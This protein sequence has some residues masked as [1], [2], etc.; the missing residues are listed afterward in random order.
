MPLAAL[1]PFARARAATHPR[2]FGEQVECILKFEV[3]DT[4]FELCIAGL[5]DFPLHACAPNAG[6]ELCIND[7][8]SKLTKKAFVET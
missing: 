5:V 8:V 2:A 6:S 1:R 7:H 3:S 4:L